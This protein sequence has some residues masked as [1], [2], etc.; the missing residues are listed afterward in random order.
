MPKRP[1]DRGPF[2]GPASRT[3]KRRR[4]AASADPLEND[5][6]KSSLES[7]ETQEDMF[8]GLVPIA[9]RPSYLS[10]EG[11]LISFD[12][13]TFGTL[14]NSQAQTDGY[15]GS[16]MSQLAAAGPA[17]AS[18]TGEEVPVAPVE[19]LDSVQEQLIQDLLAANQA[20]LGQASLDDTGNNIAQNVERIA[21]DDTGDNGRGN[22]VND[23]QPT[24][25]NEP[26]DTE[27]LYTTRVRDFVVQPS[28]ASSSSAGTI[29]QV[30]RETAPPP[31]A[32][33]EFK[34]IVYQPSAQE[35][36]SPSPPV[37]PHRSAEILHEISLDLSPP[38]TSE[39]SLSMLNLPGAVRGSPPRPQ[40]PS[41]VPAVPRALPLIASTVASGSPPPIH[42]LTASGVPL[43]WQNNVPPEDIDYV[44]K[45]NVFPQRDWL[46]S[47]CAVTKHLA[48]PNKNVAM[49]VGRLITR[50]MIAPRFHTHMTKRTK[51]MKILG[52]TLFDRFGRLRPEYKEH[53]VKRGSGIWQ[54]EFDSGDILLLESFYIDGEYQFQDL[55]EELLKAIINCTGQYSKR[56]FILVR[57]TSLLDYHYFVS[58]NL[59]G[60]VE[61]EVRFYTY[62]ERLLKLFRD[63]G[64]RR[65][66]LTPWFGWTNCLA[67][68]CHLLPA[69]EDPDRSSPTYSCP[70]DLFIHLNDLCYEDQY[71]GFIR[72]L[73]SDRL[74]EVDERHECWAQKDFRGRTLVHATAVNSKPNSLRFLLR[75]AAC[76]P[77]L[78]VRDDDGNT[79]EEALVERL[80]RCR[81]RRD[82]GTDLFDGRSIE[83]IKCLAILRGGNVDAHSHQQLKFGCTCNQCVNGFISPRMRLT[84]IRVALTSFAA[85]TVAIGHSG[86]VN[87]H[88]STFLKFVGSQVRR[89]MH[90]DVNMRRGFSRLFWH[91]RWSLERKRPPT[92]RNLHQTIRAE[93][94]PSFARYYLAKGGKLEWVAMALLDRALNVDEC[95]GTPE[96]NTVALYSNEPRC[97]NDHEY[98]LVSRMCGYKHVTNRNAHLGDEELLEDEIGLESDSDATLDQ[99]DW[100]MN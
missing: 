63:A 11:H 32:I 33:E 13:A 70:S 15:E 81:M 66:G 31:L 96:D 47:L 16:G 22:E 44:Y 39:K 80:E 19:T 51:E 55:I 10:S 1:A 99:D 91:I 28:V 49:C 64:F 93:P 100:E 65:I 38:A 87:V 3:R 90:R 69:E 14:N 84:L 82:V 75:L 58:T 36:P 62:Q 43:E 86:W 73:M 71:D 5:E 40:P 50:K 95:A 72:V 92:P 34:T 8:R 25:E 21:P 24:A 94:L 12:G 37:S 27:G 54:D 29:M 41:P 60:P 23:G 76:Q 6:T 67:H 46:R 26:A 57:P 68:R 2:P 52:F 78:Q 45:G 79:P 42:S 56:F 88:E 74:V 61:R 7:H 97:R 89:S 17:T 98:S 35:P 77:L 4:E 53:P 30:G 9:P 83:S 85:L 59:V 18:L 20:L 48:H